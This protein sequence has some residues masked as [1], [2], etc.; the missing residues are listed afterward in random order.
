MTDKNG[1]IKFGRNECDQF[2]GRF[3]VQNLSVRDMK[4]G[5]DKDKIVSVEIDGK[6]YKVGSRFSQSV[7]DHFKFHRSAL[8]LFSPGEVFERIRWRRPSDRVKVVI[9]EE[10]GCVLS[11][12]GEDTSVLPI[13][14]VMDVLKE[15]GRISE[16]NY[17]SDSGVVEAQI[18]LNERFVVRKDSGYEKGIVFSYP[19]NNISAPSVFLELTRLVCTNGMVVRRREFSTKLIIDNQNGD[20]L[21][22]ILRSYNNQD[23]FDYLHERI[24]KAQETKASMDEVDLMARIIEGDKSKEEFMPR[25]ID[26]TGS[27][28]SMYDVQSIEQVKPSMRKCLP[29]RCS[30]NDLVTFATEITTHR[31][32]DVRTRFSFDEMCGHLLAKPEFDLEGVYPHGESAP[33]F[34]F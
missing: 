11:C 30:V 24:S 1:I 16:F 12:I 23:G 9:D 8:T 19:I 17:N 18:K 29:M 34:H 31:E 27:V 2:S 4:V 14:R 25:Y 26:L 21:R 10:G 20:H 22:G 3:N 15:D 33:N 6:R 13:S 5:N 32:V 7:F 28:N